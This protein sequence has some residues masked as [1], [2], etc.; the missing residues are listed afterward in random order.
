LF[1][2][3]K[4]RHWVAFITFDIGSFNIGLFDIGLFDIGSFD[5]GLFDI[6]SF[7]I[8]SFDIGSFDIGSFDIQSFDIPLL[9]PAFICIGTPY[10]HLLLKFFLCARFRQNNK[11]GSIGALDRGIVE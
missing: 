5:I 6:G 11:Y 7:D 4:V 9:N 8:G 2:I 3:Q 10:E 1:D